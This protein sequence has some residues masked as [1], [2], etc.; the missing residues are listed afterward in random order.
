MAGELGVRSDY[1]SG[2]TFWFTLP[3]PVVQ[4]L[5]DT[6]PSPL[7]DCSQESPSVLDESDVPAS[8]SGEPS[9]R[10]LI[11]DDE[12]TN[13]IVMAET[14]RH[15][16][17]EIVTACNGQ[18]AIDLCRNGRF[19]LVF[20]DCQMPVVDGFSATTTILEEA[21]R[22]QR[23]APAIIALT[24][25]ATLAT[26]NRCQEVGMVDY[27]IKPLDFHKLQKVVSHWLPELQPSIVPGSL[28]RETTRE[29]EAAIRAMVINTAVLQRL[30]D[31]VGNITPVISVFLRSLDRRLIELERAVQTRDAEAINKV[32]HTMKGSSSQF[33]AEDLAQLCL[34]V[35][36]M[37]KNGN[38]QHIDRIFDQIA[39]AVDQVKHFFVEQLD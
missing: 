37:G 31:H 2:T 14:F 32:A 29:A 3:L 39:Q 13:R 1:G 34:L 11:V 25:D 7:P 36:H 28:A 30:R 23:K 21:A 24:A 38:I 10:L 9:L 17:V 27:L 19:N 5:V 12:E 22:Q 6:P 16:G 35:E 8:L 15:A 18:E 26:Q 20:M 4:N 33:G